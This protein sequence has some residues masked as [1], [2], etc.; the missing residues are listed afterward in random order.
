MNLSGLLLILAFMFGVT[1]TALGVLL[2]EA[3]KSK[4][5]FK[6]LVEFVKERVNENKEEVKELKEEDNDND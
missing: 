3:L 2:F 5:E 1:Y 4:R 6:T